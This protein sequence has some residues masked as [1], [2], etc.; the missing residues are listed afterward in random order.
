MNLSEPYSIELECVQRTKLHADVLQQWRFDPH[1]V[2]MSFRQNLMN[3]KQF[4]DYFQGYFYIKELPPLFAVLDGRR[5]GFIGFT[6]YVHPEHPERRSCEISILIAPEDRGQGIGARF[7][8]LALA[9]AKEQG[10]EDVYAKIKPQN[11]S[12]IHIFEKCNF[13]FIH[14]ITQIIDENGVHDR[15]PAKLFC[16]HLVQKRERK[17]V[18]IIAEAGSNWRLGTLN[19][20]LQMA[21]RLIL[22]AKEAG[23]DAV[24]FQVFRS[25]TVYV[26]NAGASD[27]LQTDEDIQ[28]IF[29][30]LA[31]PYEMIPQLAAL[32]NRV[33]IEFMATAFSV[34]D[35]KQIDPYV[36]RHKI[37]SYE[38][39]HVHLL[40]EAAKSKKPILLSTGASTLDDIAWAV[41]FLQ[42]H[43]CQDITLLQCCAQ[44]P[45]SASGMNLRAIATMQRHF[46]LPVGLSDH[47]F[48]PM[49]APIASVAL[50]ATVIEKHFT[51][52]R[53]L[54]GPDHSFAVEPDELKEMC[55]AIRLSESMLGTGIKDVLEEE[56]ELFLFARRRIQAVAPIAEG[57]KFEEG[58][59]ISILRP[60]K[61]KPGCHPKFL[62]E[63]LGKKALRPIA[64]GEG[65]ELGDW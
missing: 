21:E 26:E 11:S 33:G 20:D 39:S 52:D 59:N 51:I 22:A 46:Q 14:E 8:S 23:C 54:P 61:Q 65:I 45:A 58:R 19:R 6:P 62:D 38:I 34:E 7:L 18:F 63:I 25:N 30:D 3:E 43:G 17:K 56:K 35:F 64:L 28:S 48:D 49:T 29:T 4:W 36:V 50:G 37:A 24:K 10:C 31:M 44:Y 42:F 53:R 27:Y 12:S 57:E 13:E 15:I 1:T 41:Q 32:C 2:A 47:S 9:F 5:V 55:Q 40:E 16:L 60:G